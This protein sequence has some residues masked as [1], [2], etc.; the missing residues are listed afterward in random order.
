VSLRCRLSDARA[1]RPGLGLREAPIAVA[2]LDAPV[3]F[4]NAWAIQADRR[5]ASPFTQAEAIGA[6][7]AA[8]WL[9][10]ARGALSVHDGL[11]SAGRPARALPSACDV[12]IL[13]YRGG[14]WVIYRRSPQG[15]VG[16]AAVGPVVALRVSE[17]GQEFSTHAP[18]GDG[19]FGAVRARIDA[20]RV[21]IEARPT[22]A[23]ASVRSAVMDLDGAVLAQS[24]NDALVCPLAGCLALTGDRDAVRFAP[25]GVG[26][27]WRLV[28]ALGTVRALAVFGD[29]VLVVQR[30][31]ASARHTMV[32][33]DAARRRVET[34]F[35]ARA[36]TGVDLWSENL[37]IDSLRVSATDRG[38][39]Y[40]GVEAGAG[41]PSSG[42]IA[43]EID[44]AP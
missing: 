36:R 27:T 23:S 24:A 30:D 11:R 1:E 32:V 5:F 22:A 35:D 41:G 9:T 20:G 15:C 43:R 26:A 3:W 42:L 14:A 8:R 18:L 38:F 10:F 2:G 34:L 7:G 12:N 31:G 28:T 19:E 6:L 44:C 17:G 40:M 39:A 37:A 16:G 29:R 13:G 21:V 33:V 4:T 25:L